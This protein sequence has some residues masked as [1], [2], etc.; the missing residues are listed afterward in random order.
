[1]T[2]DVRQKIMTFFH[3][4]ITG[5]FDNVIENVQ[6][7]YKLIQYIISQ[8]VDPKMSVLTRGLISHVRYGK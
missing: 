6:R 2:T 3:F 8:S 4:A 1:M 7:K 5:L